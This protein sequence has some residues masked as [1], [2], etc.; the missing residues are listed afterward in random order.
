MAAGS[1][2]GGLLLIPPIWIQCGE[3][4]SAWRFLPACGAA[5]CWLSSGRQPA[6]PPVA[7]AAVFRF[8]LLFQPSPADWLP[9][10][11]GLVVSDW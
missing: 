9:W 4:S 8:A 6:R 5:F 1:G 7:S 11:C 2:L 3:E 10:L